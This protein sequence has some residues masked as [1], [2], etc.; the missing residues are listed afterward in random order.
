MSVERR[1]H[2]L[3]HA[4]SHSCARS[5]DCKTLLPVKTIMTV[6]GW[7]SEPDVPTGNADIDQMDSLDRAPAHT[8]FGRPL[9]NRSGCVAVSRFSLAAQVDGPDYRVGKYCRISRPISARGQPVAASCLGAHA[10][11]RLEAAKSSCYPNLALSRATP[12][13]RLDSAASRASRAVVAWSARSV[14]TSMGMR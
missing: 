8:T 6:S 11:K 13:S 12:I 14:S 4:F 1:G 2:A 10:S 3:W 9:R 5:L 7:L